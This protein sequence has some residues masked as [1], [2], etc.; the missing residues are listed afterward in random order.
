MSFINVLEWISVLF[1]LLFVVLIIKELRIGWLFGIIGSL[2]SI[3]LFYSIQLY[4][5]AVLYFYYVAMGFYGLSRWTLENDQVLPIIVWPVKKHL[6]AIVVGIIGT[7]LLGFF[8]SQYTDAAMPYVDAFST[9]FS[10]IAT[11]MEAKKIF[12]TWVFWIV[13]NTFSVWLY[14][15]RGLGIYGTLMIVYAILSV[16]GLLAWRKSLMAQRAA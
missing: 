10:F 5:E 9:S 8:F 1:N 3:Y 7:Y 2:I 6:I 13:L 16:V 4:S 15:N 14:Y 11:Y 12:S